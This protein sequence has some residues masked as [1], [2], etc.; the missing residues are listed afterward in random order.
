MHRCFK[1]KR[2]RVVASVFCVA[3]DAAISMR[4]IAVEGSR[5]DGK[6]GALRTD[7]LNFDTNVSAIAPK[8]N[9]SREAVPATLLT[10]MKDR[11]PWARLLRGWKDGNA[12]FGFSVARSGVSDG[13]GSWWHSSGTDG[14]GAGA[15]VAE[16]VGA[17]PRLIY[18]HNEYPST[19]DQH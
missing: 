18:L 2:R 3:K 15:T 8:L 17:G 12:T 19:L 1:G 9:W 5:P 10:S 16:E 6:G 4:A 13:V 14:F 11:R 7:R